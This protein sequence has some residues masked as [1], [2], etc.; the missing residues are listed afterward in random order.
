MNCARIVTLTFVD[1]AGF[2]A[3]K[4][5]VP[6][7]LPAFVEQAKRI[8]K[9][10]VIPVDRSGFQ[11]AARFSRSYQRYALPVR[12]GPGEHLA[13]GIDVTDAS[14]NPRIAGICSE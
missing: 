11:I 9:I 12:C 14:Q 5:F 13:I 7:F 10:E 4:I 3:I 2:V 8:V 1:G 6:E